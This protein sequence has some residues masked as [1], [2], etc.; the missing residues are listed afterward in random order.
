MKM[1]Q[2]SIFIKDLYIILLEVNNE[3]IYYES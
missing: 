1:Y 2:P 3:N